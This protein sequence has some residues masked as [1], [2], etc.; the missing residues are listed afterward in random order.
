MTYLAEEIDPRGLGA[1]MGLYIAGNAFGGMAGRVVTGAYRRILLLAPGACRVGILG[2]PPAIGFMLLLPP[3]RNFVPRKGFNAG[4]HL[5]AWLGH[6][7]QPGPAF[8]LCHRLSRHGLL[9]H[10]L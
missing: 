1:S 2:L 4:F 3:S 8:A 6:L 5:K 9:R 7:R 10:R